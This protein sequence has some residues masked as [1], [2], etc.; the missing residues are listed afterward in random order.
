M[1]KVL[2]ATAIAALTSGVAVAENGSRT[3]AMYAQL[4]AANKLTISVS[5][6]CTGSVT[7]DNFVNAGV[8]DIK[9]SGSTI[10]AIN[11][12]AGTVGIYEINPV[13]LENLPT[14][15]DGNPDMD[16]VSKDVLSIMAGSFGAKHSYSL[17]YNAKKGETF[18]VTAPAE[19]DADQIYKA[20]V[21]KGG[22]SCKSG[23][24]FA[25]TVAKYPSMGPALDKLLPFSAEAPQYTAKSSKVTLQLTTDGDLDPRT[26]AN[27]KQKI[28]ITGS[29]NSTPVCTVKGTLSD[30]GLV[31]AGCKAGAPINIKISA[32]AVGEVGY[33][34]LNAIL[35]S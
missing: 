17:A 35:G 19:Y 30:S 28:T 8:W 5:G 13:D 20:I 31:S 10:D 15:E 1:K 23:S 29:F 12:M 2:L 25:D 14:D 9:G 33:L 11:Q 16:A 21:T 7:L 6:A 26:T 24:S 27:V 32:N 34:D 3:D 22:V 4:K 18:K